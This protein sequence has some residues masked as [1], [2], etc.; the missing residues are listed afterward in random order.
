MGGRGRVRVTGS[1]VAYWKLKSDSE[2]Q[3]RFEQEI[4][5]LMRPSVSARAGWKRN[6]RT[7]TAGSCTQ[8]FENLIDE[9]RKK[10]RCNRSAA[11]RGKVEWEVA[12]G[13]ERRTCRR[14]SKM[15]ADCRWPLLLPVQLFDYF[16]VCSLLL[17]AQP[18]T[19]GQAPITKTPLSIRF[20]DEYALLG[21]RMT[22]NKIVR[23][24]RRCTSNK[25]VR[26]EDY[27]PEIR[28]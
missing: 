4:N 26:C 24:P 10:V 6:S 7:T 20:Y 1:V 15:M 25:I 11:H 9:V 18:S 27:P 5:W 28:L 14:G 17:A 3:E 12:F 23:C 2:V 8:E 21:H 19:C 16:R 13:R 22:S